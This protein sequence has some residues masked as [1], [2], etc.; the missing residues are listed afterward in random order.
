MKEIAIVL[1]SGFVLT[2]IWKWRESKW[3]L[4]FQKIVNR[5]MDFKKNRDKLHQIG[6]VFIGLVFGLI[7]YLTIGL[8]WIAFLTFVIN[9]TVFWLLDIVLNVFIDQEPFYRGKTAILDKIPF[10]VRFVLLAVLIVILWI[11]QK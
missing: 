2:F 5:D 4:N 9:C 6:M 11:N 7:S 1:F 10:W 8:T 3:I